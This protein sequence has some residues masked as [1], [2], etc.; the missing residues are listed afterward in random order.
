MLFVNENK[1]SI[2]FT[3][4]TCHR[5]ICLAQIVAKKS[6]QTVPFLLQTD[7]DFLISGCNLQLIN[8]SL[9]TAATK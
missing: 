7:Y 1:Q 5:C 8:G 2:T 4:L 6:L 3:P 9:K